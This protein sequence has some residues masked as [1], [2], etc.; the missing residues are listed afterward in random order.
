MAWNIGTRPVFICRAGQTMNEEEQED[1]QLLPKFDERHYDNNLSNALIGRE[2][3]ILETEEQ[4]LSSW[5]EE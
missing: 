3:M 4:S 5:V 2:L 1:Y